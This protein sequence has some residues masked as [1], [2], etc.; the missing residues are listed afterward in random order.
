MQNS[1]K[2]N[3]I[4]NL[5]SNLFRLILRKKYEI[6]FKSIVF[7]IWEKKNSNDEI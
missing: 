2:I 4:L 7:T 1:M 6:K 5:R 3:L